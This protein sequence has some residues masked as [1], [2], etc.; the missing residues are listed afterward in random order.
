MNVVV[1]IAIAAVI[2]AGLGAVQAYLAPRP[3]A[4]PVAAT[5]GAKP[6]EPKS[7]AV[8]N[9][10]EMKPIIVN[11]SS[12][13]G[14]WARLEAALVF[15]KADTATRD[16]TVAE[17]SGDFAAYLRTLQPSAL[18]GASGLLE[19]RE[20]LRERASLRTGGAVGDV[21]IETLV[22]Q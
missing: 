4:Q 1:S 16:K 22:V 6:H 14:A 9:V 10:V 8:S 17:V 15:E 21:I 18:E 5:S 11:L 12:T 20:D 19:L 13:T 3:I 2:G 7:D